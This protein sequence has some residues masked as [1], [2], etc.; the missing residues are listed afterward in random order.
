MK[1]FSEAMPFYRANFHCHTTCSDGRKPLAEAMQIYRDAG[2]DILAI[3]DHKKLTVPEHVPDG[4]LWMPGIE[5][6]YNRAGIVTHLVGLGMDP[7]IEQVWDRSGTPQDG[8]DL[9]VRMGGAAILAHPAWSLNTPAQINALHGLS[10][11]EIWNTVSALPHNADR[12][13]SSS[14]L[15]AA[16][17]TGGQLLPVVASDDTHFYDTDAAFASTMLQAES[18]SVESVLDALRLGR[19]YATQGPEIRQIE[20]IENRE[21]IV[22]CS[23]ADTVIFYSNTPSVKERVRFGRGI[24]ESVYT[25]HPTDRFV[26]VEIRDATGRKAWSSPVSVGEAGNV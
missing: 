23:P 11:V 7:A 5:L 19:F 21:L 2:Y 18:L 10:A 22:H 14:L 12:G 1:L 6:D 16:W 25:I 17:A 3:T 24:T 8:I 4:L 26:R 20:L 9:I 15:D 13:D